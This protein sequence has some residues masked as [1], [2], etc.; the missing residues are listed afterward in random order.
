M[1]NVL[2]IYVMAMCLGVKANMRPTQEIFWFPRRSYQGNDSGY[3][4]IPQRLIWGP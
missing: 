3:A 1:N 4:F 2:V